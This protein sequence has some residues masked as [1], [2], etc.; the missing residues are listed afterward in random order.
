MLLSSRRQRVL[1]LMCAVLGAS[2][3]GAS[4]G[5]QWRIAAAAAGMLLCAA[6]LI[7]VDVSGRARNLERRQAV[8][9]KRVD[10][11]F[12]QQKREATASRS[13][14]TENA[15]RIIDAVESGDARLLEAVH[16]AHG[17]SDRLGTVED[18]VVRLEEEAARQR[19][20]HAGFRKEVFGVIRDQTREVEAL[21]Q[22]FSRVS[23]RQPMPSSG[24]WALDAT[25][26]LNL[27]ALVQ[28]DRPEL[29]VELGSGT[30]TVWL[31]YALEAAGTGRLVSVDHLDEFAG[32]ARAAVDLHGNRDST[33]VR[34]APLTPL[35]LG[36]EEFAWYDR[37][38]LAD[39][40][41]IDMLVVDGPPKVTGR[42]ARYPALPVLLEHL[43]DDAL[44]VL[45]D[46]DRS[47]EQ[48]IVDRWLE[49][50]PGL[51]REPVLVGAQA[52]LRYT[53]PGAEVA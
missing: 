48:K 50:V 42:H 51:R 43:A 47:S 10:G 4:A 9:S 28:R 40:D 26:L 34:H 32:H 38:A 17:A 39:L 11:L 31:G 15:A 33:E 22:L 3:V 13:S 24:R 46:T 53:R 23:P 12:T 8:L 21:L 37:S 20:T 41:G 27:Y 2:S 45:D 25:G 35:R 30:S 6:V 52:V 49:T 5:G 29:V 44:V 36:D 18:G 19:Q 1:A 16:A 14:L 7:L